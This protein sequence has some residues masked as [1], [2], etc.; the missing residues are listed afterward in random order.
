MAKYNASNII[1]AFDAS[2]G[3]TVKTMTQYITDINGISVEAVLEESHTF[4]DSW[5]ESL[6]AGLKRA[7]E[8]TMSG[9]YDDT[10]TDGPDAV[11][12][13]IG[14]TTLRTLTITFGGSKTFSTETIIKSYTRTPA[15][16]GLTKFSVVL[17]PT[18]T[19]TE[20]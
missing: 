6:F 13:G 8:I 19:V 4:G 18:G 3:T 15:R 14:N 17:V 9:F 1:I 12:I 10:A 7:G 16:G 2:D 5:A 20:A 11:F